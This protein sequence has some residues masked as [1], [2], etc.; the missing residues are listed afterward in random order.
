MYGCGGRAWLDW[1]GTDQS[2]L[3]TLQL[4]HKQ[5]LAYALKRS[6]TR[7]TNII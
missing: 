5:L 7:T 2:S 4:Q 3:S 1:E 6:E